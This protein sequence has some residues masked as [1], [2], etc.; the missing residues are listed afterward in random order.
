MELSRSFLGVLS[1][2]ARWNKARYKRG[3]RDGNLNK[4][5]FLV[6]GSSLVHPRFVFGSSLVFNTEQIGKELVKGILIKVLF[7]NT[8]YIRR[9]CLLEC[10]SEVMDKENKCSAN[11]LSI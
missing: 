6:V 8:S 10:D 11:L 2:V 1:V 7:T 9:S 3:K 4:K 5:H